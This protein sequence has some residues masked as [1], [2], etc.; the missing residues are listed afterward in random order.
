MVTFGIAVRI[1]DKD[2]ATSRDPK[3]LI[4]DRKT[5]GGEWNYAMRF[6][7]VLKPENERERPTSEQ[8]D[9]EIEEDETRE[10]P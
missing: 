6:Y 7:K 9:F 3:C 2:V 1:S 4:F 8:I 5:Y 10:T